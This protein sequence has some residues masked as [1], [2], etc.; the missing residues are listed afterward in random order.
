MKILHVL[1]YS[2]LNIL[3]LAVGI[4][5]VLLFNCVTENIKFHKKMS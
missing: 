3:G 2:L 1:D 4:G 5:C